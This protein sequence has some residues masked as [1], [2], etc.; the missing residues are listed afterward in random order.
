MIIIVDVLFMRGRILGICA[1]SKAPELSSNALQKILGN[2]LEETMPWAFISSSKSM[3]GMTWCKATLNAAYSA[4]VVDK[5]K[6]PASLE[7][8]AST[9]SSLTLLLGLLEPR[10]RPCNM[11][12][13][14]RGD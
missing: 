14:I 5:Q 11:R 8:D 7:A 3:T 4:S 12:Y 9:K 2:C 13:E 1:I 6:G 10:S